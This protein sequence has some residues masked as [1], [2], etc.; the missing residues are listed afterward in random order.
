MV[1]YVRTKSGLR[2]D[3]SLTLSFATPAD[4]VLI[5]LEWFGHPTETISLLFRF[6]ICHNGKP[7]LSGDGA[8]VS[9]GSSGV[10][11][12]Y[13]THGRNEASFSA[14]TRPL[15]PLTSYIGSWHHVPG[16][17]AYYSRQFSA[18]CLRVRLYDPLSAS[19]NSFVTLQ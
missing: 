6:Q 11:C 17:S 19:M 4:Q 14:M 10:T 5:A 7:D 16:Q 13:W 3:C 8:Y 12:A 2:C 15:M 18:G 1:S 9:V